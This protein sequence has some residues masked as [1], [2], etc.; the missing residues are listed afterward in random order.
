MK[1]SI[2]RLKPRKK[3]VM[4]APAESLYKGAGPSVTFEGG[5]NGSTV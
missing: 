5:N 4:T 2:E 1:N 3:E